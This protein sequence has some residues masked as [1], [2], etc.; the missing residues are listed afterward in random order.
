MKGRLTG[1]LLVGRYRVD[2]LVA[3]GGS[4]E[5]YSA[6]HLQ[7]GV[8]VA[9]K[10]LRR[11]AATD[12]A[13]D[14]E[15]ELSFRRERA[16]LLALRHPNIVSVL[17]SGVLESEL[18]GAPYLV[19]AWCEGVRLSTPVSYTHLTLPTSDLV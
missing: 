18:G 5:V 13:L 1:T 16:V 8:R 14:A 19:L 10:V 11:D 4:S 2:A 17:D 9:L 12:P 7:L 15:Q 6:E 3:A